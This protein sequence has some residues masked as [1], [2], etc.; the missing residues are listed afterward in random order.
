[1]NNKLSQ[2]EQCELML[3]RLADIKKDCNDSME[4]FK[5]R[6]SIENTENSIVGDA[7]VIRKNAVIPPEEYDALISRFEVRPLALYLSRVTVDMHCFSD[8]EIE[9]TRCFCYWPSSEFLQVRW[10]SN[11]E[12]PLRN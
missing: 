7:R 3:H 11:R 10:T 6:L 1:M 9:W 2:T 12:Y 8:S 4:E 5:R